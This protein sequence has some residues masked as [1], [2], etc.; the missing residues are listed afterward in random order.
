MG[1]V[2]LARDLVDRGCQAVKQAGLSADE[3]RSFW[4]I[5]MLEAAAIIN[6]RAP[7]TSL[8]VTSPGPSKQLPLPMAPVD[9]KR[10]LMRCKRCKR[11]RPMDVKWRR[12]ANGTRHLEAK[13][14]SC[15]KHVAFL[16]QVE[17]N[18]QWVER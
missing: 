11:D 18:L 7:R 9:P 13:C 8:P 10:K 1:S 12:F 15:G 3:V 2:E 16:P 5:V 17:S 14:H 6:E 4:H